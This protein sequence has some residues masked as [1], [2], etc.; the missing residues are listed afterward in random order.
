MSLKAFH[1]FFMIVS[2]LFCLGF[3]VWAVQDGGE[4]LAMGLVSLAGCP[5]LTLYGVW[6][7][8]KMK[9]WSYL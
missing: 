3:G 1:I 2:I 6:F 7:L 4:N 8:R 9:G 5:V